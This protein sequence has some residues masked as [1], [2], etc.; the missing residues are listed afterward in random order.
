MSKKTS[1]AQYLKLIISQLEDG[2]DNAPTNSRTSYITEAQK[3]FAA[4]ENSDAKSEPR[5]PELGNDLAKALE[6]SQEIDEVEK[7]I[8]N[9]TDKKIHK[10]LDDHLFHLVEG[11]IEYA[12]D[13]LETSEALL[14]KITKKRGNR[15][16]A[17]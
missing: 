17:E 12:G 5:L 1:P 9:N 15:D 2:R 14:T 4:L 8:E 11:L 6:I 3:H 10:S 7:N 13:A 16:R